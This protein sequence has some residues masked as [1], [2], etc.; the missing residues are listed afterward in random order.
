MGATIVVSNT[1]DSISGSRM[2]DG[3]RRRSGAAD[4]ES[5]D[6]WR[7]SGPADIEPPMSAI[8][9]VA[10]RKLSKGSLF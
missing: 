2:V 10:A 1:Q 8:T 6:A 7:W 4:G 5:H 3:D 9:P